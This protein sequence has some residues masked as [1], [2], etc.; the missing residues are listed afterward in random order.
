M[1][2]D[3]QSDVQSGK[4]DTGEDPEE[5]REED[6]MMTSSNGRG[7]HGP[8]RPKTEICGGT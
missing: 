6:G 7:Q 2:T 4:S 1:I 3:G 8:E 5:G